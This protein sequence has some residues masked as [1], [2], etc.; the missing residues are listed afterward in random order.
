MKGK[1]EV[2]KGMFAHF[3]SGFYGELYFYITDRIDENFPAKYCI[4]KG[5]K[6]FHYSDGTVSGTRSFKDFNDL[7]RYLERKNRA[8]FQG[9]T[10]KY[11]GIL[12]NMV[13]FSSKGKI[14]ILDASKMKPLRLDFMFPG[15]GIGF[16]GTCVLKNAKVPFTYYLHSEDSKTLERVLWA[17]WIER[18]GKRYVD[19][20][21]YPFN[22]SRN[23]ICS[24]MRYLGK[25]MVDNNIL[26]YSEIPNT[27]I[28]SIKKIEYTCLLLYAL[29]TGEHW[30][31]P[32]I[33]D[34]FISK[35]RTAEVVIHADIIVKIDGKTNHIN[36]IFNIPY[37]SRELVDVLREKHFNIREEIEVNTLEFLRKQQAQRQHDEEHEHENYIH[38]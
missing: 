7:V 26:W 32:M 23:N 16:P 4:L 34:S 28:L 18:N 5:K 29:K 8:F 11:S 31:L 21:Y 30:V 15:T 20:L 2:K 10:N 33:L 38:R 35:K 19:M 9:L 37:V 13:V 24:P 14:C 1:T 3:T 22:V 17:V 36:T 27:D 25:T 12:G 6:Y